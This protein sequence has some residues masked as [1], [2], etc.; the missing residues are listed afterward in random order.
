[1]AATLGLFIQL[2]M[3]SRVTQKIVA[4]AAKVDPSTV[5]LALNNSPNLPA[6]TRD[7]IIA[8]A[9][10]LGYQR[11]PMLGALAAYRR[12]AAEPAF[13]GVLGWIVTSAGGYNWRLPPEYRD[14]HTGAIA[15]ATQLGYQLET[16]DLNDYSSN[17][18]RLNGVLR[19]RNIR[20]ILVCPQP[21]AH[22]LLDLKI[23]DLSAVTFGYTV[24]S[25]QLHMVSSHHYAAIRQ[26]LGELRARAYKRIGY[27]IP[28]SHNERLDHNYMAGYLLEQS[29]WPVDE[30]L[31]PFVG[32]PRIGP[33]R[34]WLR[35]ARPDALVTTHYVFPEMVA[36]LGIKAPDKLGLAII[37]LADNVHAYAGI[38]E[39]SREVGRVAIGLLASLV[40]RGEK[41]LPARPQR[42]LVR[43]IWREGQSLRARPL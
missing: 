21:Q 20:G 36:A 6:G 16:L 23:E 27:A 2:N 17:P 9:A 43:G 38:D 4:L 1:M 19:A 42:V 32:E 11:D 22:T 40:E 14:Y 8:I 37:S 7:R 29:Q 28:Q 12:G 15:A 10:K 30:R 39:D 25:P 31:P 3:S 34:S 33:F 41:G 26:T 13:H 5:C 24:K 35:A 18:K